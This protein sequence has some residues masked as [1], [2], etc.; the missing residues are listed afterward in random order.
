MVTFSL[1]GTKIPDTCNMKKERFFGG[2]HCFRKLQSII[3]WSQDCTITTG[4]SCSGY[5]TWEAE[6]KQRASERKK[7]G[8]R[9]S[10]QAHTP[11][12]ES[13][14]G[15]HLL[16]AHSAVNSLV[17]L[18]IDGEHLQYKPLRDS[19][20]LNYNTSSMCQS[21]LCHPLK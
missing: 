2:A 15:S 13:P 11:W 14:T 6:S 17:T 7:P 8:T 1:A 3:D 18:P 9:C 12:P 20:Y 16:I 10:P 5:G 4:E 21:P 19:S